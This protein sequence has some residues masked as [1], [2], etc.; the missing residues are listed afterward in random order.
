MDFNPYGSEVISPCTNEDQE[1]WNQHT[2]QH[3]CIDQA[4]WWR[5]GKAGSQRQLSARGI[6]PVT[7]ILGDVRFSLRDPL[8]SKMPCDQEG[9]QPQAAQ[10][11]EGRKCS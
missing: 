5:L 2:S 3:D 10:K 1:T 9:E 4:E 6:L 7:C 11:K 8:H